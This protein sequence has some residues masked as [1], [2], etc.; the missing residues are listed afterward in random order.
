MSEKP[1]R[2]AVYDVLVGN[3]TGLGISRR[4]TRQPT[5]GIHDGS[6]TANDRGIDLIEISSRRGTATAE[7][8]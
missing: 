2:Y 7:S 1:E 5:R 8:P 4:G 6:D 3:T